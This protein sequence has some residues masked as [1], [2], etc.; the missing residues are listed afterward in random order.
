MLD[1][2]ICG[3]NIRKRNLKHSVASYCI[4]S[5]VVPPTLSP[6]FFY[7]E[8]NWSHRKLRQSNQLSHSLENT[9][10]IGLQVLAAGVALMSSPHSA[11]ANRWSFS[12]EEVQSSNDQIEELSDKVKALDDK[13]EKIMTSDHK[14]DYQN[15][16]DNGKKRTR[17]KSSL[18]LE[19]HVLFTSF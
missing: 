7:N 16:G 9:I 5:I 18:F 15:S 11:E 3:W 12:R 10:T 4:D 6:F 17:T 14:G 2:L 1:C 13:D 19:V 8:P